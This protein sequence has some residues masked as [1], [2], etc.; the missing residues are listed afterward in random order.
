[1]DGTLTKWKR[2]KKEIPVSKKYK[3]K[4]IHHK[5]EGETLII[6]MPKRD[7]LSRFKDGVW[8][9]VQFVIVIVVGVAVGAFVKKV[10]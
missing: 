4:E 7:S 10:F 3:T 5:F 9:T 2:L 8:Q 6:E 1:M